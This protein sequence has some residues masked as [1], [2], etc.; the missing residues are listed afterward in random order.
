MRARLHKMDEH[1][2]QDSQVGPEKG[3]VGA[4]KGRLVAAVVC[5]ERPVKLVLCLCIYIYI[6]TV[7]GKIHYRI[8]CIAPNAWE[9]QQSKT[10]Q[11]GSTVMVVVK[12]SSLI[13]ISWS[14]CCR[15]GKKD[16]A[17]LRFNVPDAVLLER[18][19]HR[20]KNASNA[21]EKKRC[22]TFRHMHQ[23]IG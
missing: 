17:H 23:K 15:I 2:G 13:G 21:S 6:K 19:W 8:L 18:C 4:Q 3:Q 10:T 1:G 16:T 11:S 9:W 20:C 12:R 14:T 7:L 5:P 22:L